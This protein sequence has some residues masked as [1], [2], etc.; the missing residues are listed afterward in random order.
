MNIKS[1]RQ[2]GKNLENYICDQIR[3][4]GLDDKAIR[5]PGSG[6]GT[7]EKADISTSL[8]ILGRNI[9]I[10]SKHHKTLHIQDWW[11]QTKLLEKVGYEPVLAFKQTQDDYAETK[12]V[13]YLNTYL[14]MCKRCQEP[15]TVDTQSQDIKWAVKNLKDN[16][17]KLLKLLEE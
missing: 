4:K 11:Q 9:G 5:S 7:R 2:K 10:E 15:K 12:V 13:I 16:A 3:A 1:A 8:T 14:D 17:H 6:N